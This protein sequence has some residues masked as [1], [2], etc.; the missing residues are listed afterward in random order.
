MVEFVEKLDFLAL[1]TENL[2]KQADGLSSQEIKPKV[3]GSERGGLLLYT[4]Y[5]KQKKRPSAWKTLV[6]VYDTKKN[7]SRNLFSHNDK[8]DIVHASVSQPLIILAF[9]VRER[10]LIDGKDGSEEKGDIFKSYIAEIAPQKRIFSLN[11]EW[12]TYQKVQFLYQ[13]NE[14]M[15]ELYMLFIH[16]KESIGLYC[17]PVAK[18]GDDGF[19]MSSQPK[20]DQI[21]RKFLWSKFDPVEQRLFYVQ[22][23]AQDEVEQEGSLTF[24]AVQ[25]DR[26]G[27]YTYILSFQLPFSLNME[28]MREKVQYYDRYLSLCLS[29]RNVNIETL[30]SNKGAL[31]ICYQ[32]Q[33]E[34]VGEERGSTPRPE[35]ETISLSTSIQSNYQVSYTIFCIHGG[36]SFTCRVSLN[37]EIAIKSQM[38]FTMFGDY[39]MVLLPGHFIHLLDCGSEHEPSHHIFLSENDCPMGPIISSKGALFSTATW[40]FVSSMQHG[41]ILYENFS[42]KSY[43]VSF[44]PKALL[45]TFSTSRHASTRM[46]I[47]HAAVVHIKDLSF[48]KKLI[49]C[50]CQDPANLECSDL[51]KEYLIASSYAHIKQQLSYAFLRPFPFTSLDSFRGH[52]ERNRESHRAVYLRYK[53]FS[54]DMI[55]V[56]LYLLKDRDMDFWKTLKQTLKLSQDSNMKRFPLSS[57]SHHL[58]QASSTLAGGKEPSSHPGSTVSLLES[59]RKVAID[60]TK[61]NEGG[62]A[63]QDAMTQ[64]FVE[65]VSAHILKCFPL[66]SKSRVQ[67]IC[68]EYASCRCKVVKSFWRCLTKVLGYTQDGDVYSQPLEKTSKATDFALFQMLERLYMNVKQLCFPQFKGMQNVFIAL[69]YRCLPNHLFRQYIRVSVFKATPDFIRRFVLEVPDDDESS[70]LKLDLVTSLPKSIAKPIL[71]EWSHPVA[72]HFLTQ[73]LVGKFDFIEKIHLNNSMLSGGAESEQESDRFLPVET[74]LRFVNLPAFASCRLSEEELDFLVGSAQ[75]SLGNANIR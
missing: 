15:K 55:D 59:I 33:Q 43:K 23:R 2:E 56:I 13:G 65:S 58:A 69:G 74:F 72:R 30:T 10:Q 49:E 27:K 18:L 32:H 8:I 35:D 16:H 64:L 21:V 63:S 54:K 60:S 47:L 53:K 7:V 67:N 57:L 66:E 24:N 51:I 11:I 37:V 44:K 61:R 42:Q 14:P 3:V 62:K 52:L 1:I 46:A 50:L 70:T 6:S 22:L 75:S 28:L 29:N 38:L 68:I 31:M 5:K 4:W 20:T 45:N 41:T 36:Y 9:T 40:D 26:R 39:L 71:M 12:H 17:I 19:V 25:F 34:V 48:N 73:E